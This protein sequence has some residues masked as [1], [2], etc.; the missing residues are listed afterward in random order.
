VKRSFSSSEV[1]WHETRG[2]RGF[3]R[4]Q[5]LNDNLAWGTA[6]TARAISWTHVDD[7][8]FGTVVIVRT[9]AKYWVIMRPRRDAEW[10]RK[11]GNLATNKAYPQ[12][13]EPRK[14]SGKGL[15]EAEGLLLMKGSVL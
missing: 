6:A 14:H 8:G 3:I 4:E 11:A 2:R 5:P 12:E 9:G 7:D 1:A 13:W 10:D 15:W